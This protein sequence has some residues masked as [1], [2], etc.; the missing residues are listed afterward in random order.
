MEGHLPII[1]FLGTPFG[2]G[3]REEGYAA[4]GM[5]MKRFAYQTARARRPR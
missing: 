5:P 4:A 2:D 3:G 1:S